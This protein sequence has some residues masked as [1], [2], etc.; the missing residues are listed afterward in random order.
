MKSWVSVS[1][2][3]SWALLFLCLFVLNDSN[4]LVFVLS[5]YIMLLYYIIICII[6]YYLRSLFSN[7]NLKGSPDGRRGGEEVG[8]AEG[9]ETIIRSYPVRNFSIFNKRKNNRQ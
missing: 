1:C 6:L 3:F 8:N 2:A 4:L 9:A 5:Y 7:K